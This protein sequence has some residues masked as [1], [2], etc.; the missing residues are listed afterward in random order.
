M[1]Q[2]KSTYARPRKTARMDAGLHRVMRNFQYGIPGTEQNDE[3][4]PG[5]GHPWV[6]VLRYRFGRIDGWL[7][8]DAFDSVNEAFRRPKR[9]Q[10]I[11]TILE[12]CGVYATT[13][14]LYRETYPPVFLTHHVAREASLD[15]LRADLD[16]MFGLSL[17]LRWTHENGEDYIEKDILP[18]CRVLPLIHA[19]VKEGQRLIVHRIGTEQNLRHIAKHGAKTTERNTDMLGRFH[20]HERQDIEEWISADARMWLEKTFDAGLVWG[21]DMDNP[22][23]DIHEEVLP[24]LVS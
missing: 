3:R 1:E 15:R 19:A 2:Q 18:Q 20:A 10:A 8:L 16:Y 9:D 23:G 14:S 11:A 22:T 6:Q 21:K 7:A 5:T 17:V 24:A 12:E 13:E 4:I